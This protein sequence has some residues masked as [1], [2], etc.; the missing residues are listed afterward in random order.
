MCVLRVGCLQMAV[1]KR[2][3]DPVVTEI[4]QQP[5]VLAPDE[6]VRRPFGG[7]HTD[8]PARGHGPFAARCVA[9]TITTTEASK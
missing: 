7:D 1:A 8:Q 6:S 3:R 4:D 9:G 5:N 2:V